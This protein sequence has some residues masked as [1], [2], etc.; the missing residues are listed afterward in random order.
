MSAIVPELDLAPSVTSRVVTIDVIDMQE[1]APAGGSVD[2]ILAADLHVPADDKII[3]AGSVTVTLNAAGHGEVRLPTY[4]PDVR[5]D[6]WG[7]LVKKSWAP[8]PYLIRV[9]AGDVTPISLADIEPVQEADQSTVQWLLTGAA[10][11]VVEGAAWNITV[12]VSGGIAKFKF[13]VPPAAVP[14][15]RGLWSGGGDM[16]EWRTSMRGAWEVRDAS[17]YARPANFPPNVP[18]NVPS[19]VVVDAT[20]GGHTVQ[21]VYPT[22]TGQAVWFRTSK[23]FTGTGATAWNDWRRVDSGIRPRLSNGTDLNTLRLQAHEGLYSITATQAATLTNVPHSAAAG[24]LVVT[25]SLDGVA[26]QTFYDLSEG[27]TRLWWRMINNAAQFT[28]APWTVV[29]GG[30]PS[31]GPGEK[32]TA[33]L[34]L[35]VGGGPTSTTVAAAMNARLPIRPSITIRRWR[36]HLRNYNYRD[37]QAYPGALSLAGIVVGPAALDADGR[38]T[39]AFAAAPTQVSGAGTTPAAATEYVTPWSDVELTAGTDYLVGYAYTAAVDQQTYLAVGGGWRNGTPDDLAVLAPTLTREQYMP[40]DVWVEA[41][42]DPGTEVVA[43]FGDSLTVGVGADLPVYDSFPWRLARIRNHVPVIYGASGSTMNLWTN[44]SAGQLTRWAGFT[45]PSR[46]YWAMGSNDVFQPVDIATLRARFA[47]AWPVVTGATSRN[48]VLT[49]I[50]P[51]LDAG[52]AAE[53]V[54]QQWNNLLVDELPGGAQ[55]CIDTAA[56]LTDESGAVLDPRWRATPTNIHLSKQGYA[57]LASTL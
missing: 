15:Y 17:G 10:V 55:M 16:D 4:D 50:L 24:S 9:P 11:E 54:R 56:V 37:A 7:I 38:P 41:E 5:P 14:W 53:A 42:F 23:V 28:W 46:L 57:R 44:P 21:T 39:G 48:V 20:A 51:R 36:V 27:R 26:T 6:G 49:T 18:A 47:A 22:G 35:T 33:P 3:Q 25:A 13:T 45:K 43:Y 12:D 2:F 52:A 29:V 30:G 32:V 34:A 1:G 31:P 40:L 8:H 19:I